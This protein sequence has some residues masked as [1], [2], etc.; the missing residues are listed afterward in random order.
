ML[1]G[2]NKIFSSIRAALVRLGKVIG[3]K[4]K[5][6]E[7]QLEKRIENIMDAT[8]SQTVETEV[9]KE[10]QERRKR[11]RKR[12]HKFLLNRSDRRFLT[13]VLGEEFEKDEYG[14][15]HKYKVSKEMYQRV[16]ILKN[17]KISKEKKRAI[18][19]KFIT[20]GKF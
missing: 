10:T 9:S 5:E 2:I 7:K 12:E 19:E 4:A 14:E 1:T 11:M 16:Q 15:S 20:T 6:T 13:S 17:I 18:A 3:L 8:V